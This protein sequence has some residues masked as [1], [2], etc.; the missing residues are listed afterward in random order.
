MRPEWRE[1]QITKDSL[2]ISSC[3]ALRYE[4]AGIQTGLAH[5]VP[6][7][8]WRVRGDERWH[9]IDIRVKPDDEALAHCPWPAI[10]SVDFIELKISIEESN[11]CAGWIR[12]FDELGHP[13]GGGGSWLNRTCYDANKN[14]QGAVPPP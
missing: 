7:L 1:L 6:G 5:I 8:A 12:T 13:G 14:K 10:N 11:P 4:V 3:G 9:T 2:I